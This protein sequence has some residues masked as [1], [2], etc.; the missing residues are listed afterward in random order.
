MGRLDASGPI[1]LDGPLGT[2]LTDRGVATDLP[3]WSAAA[4]PTHADVISAIHRD[5]AT[6]GAVVHTTNTFRT[7]RRDVG[8]DWLEWTS[9]AVRLARQAIS[10]GHLVAGSLSPL[11]D[12]Y[13]PNRSP[14][15]SDPLGCQAEHQ[16]MAMALADSRCDWILCETFPLLREARI[17]LEAG[18]RTG[19][20]TL[21]A[22]TAGPDGSLMSPVQMAEAALDVAREGAAAVMV[23][24]TPATKTL[25]YVESMVDRVSI[26]VGAYANAGRVDDRL[27]WSSPSESD[28]EGAAQRYADLAETWLR[29][30]ATLVGGCCGTT[31]RHTAALDRL[32]R[33]SRRRHH[34]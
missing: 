8:E 27:G 2:Q 17:A 13:Q 20:P 4:I 9:T 7:K 10:P 16:E 34:P 29:A 32:L 3:L 6:A 26:P 15:F 25:A 1:L 28:T 18:M 21:V 22:F 23:N 30:G 24:C 19:L 5:Y 14:A 12:C 31:P 11:A 33:L